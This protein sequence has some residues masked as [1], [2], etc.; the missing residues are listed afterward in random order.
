M[1]ENKIWNLDEEL[2]ERSG[3]RIMVIG[4]PHFQV[5]NIAEVKI[6][7][8]KVKLYADKIK[9]RFIVCLGDI[10]H[11]YETI[12]VKPFMCA[13]EFLSQMSQI[14]ETYLLIGNH[15]RPNNFNFLTNE[16]PFNS[17][18]KYP[19]LTIVD[20][21]IAKIIDDNSYL[22]VPYV[23][24]GRFL[25]ALEQS[26]VNFQ[27]SRIIF[28]HQEFMG[29][30]F[31]AIRSKNGDLWPRDYPLII[32]GHIHDYE[33]LQDNILYVGSSIQQGYGDSPNKTISILDVTTQSFQEYRI[34]LGLT[35]KIQY[36]LKVDDLN[37][38]I[39]DPNQKIKCIIH[40]PDHEIKSLLKSDK[41]SELKSAGVL[42][43]FKAIPKTPSTLTSTGPR[44]SYTQRLYETISTDMHQTKWFNILFHTDK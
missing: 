20:T 43:E 42:I 1:I 2:P 36:N 41:V 38:F 10:L 29:A 32:S 18:K 30:K 22:F 13:E 26:P 5:R 6:F 34:N 11:R 27:Q 24:T 31:K 3:T 16:H 25:E 12:H 4:D 37:N 8:S 21:V 9:P 40:A 39:P 23:E 33:R 17:F 35:A 19:N 7:I 44:M 28:A 14:A 15:D